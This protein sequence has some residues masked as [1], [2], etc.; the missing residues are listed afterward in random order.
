[1]SRGAREWAGSTVGSVASRVAMPSPFPCRASARILRRAHDPRQSRQ[2]HRRLPHIL[3]GPRCRQACSARHARYSCH[4]GGTLVLDR[5]AA[6]WLLGAVEPACNGSAGP[7]AG[8]LRCAR[9][10]AIIS[11]SWAGRFCEAEKSWHF[12]IH[13]ELVAARTGV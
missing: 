12:R 6:D 4:A 1:M 5:A 13:P 10:A 2:D 7:G 8:P 3:P 9:L 11:C